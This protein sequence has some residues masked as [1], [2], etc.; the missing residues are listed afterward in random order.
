MTISKNLNGGRASWPLLLFAMFALIGASFLAAAVFPLEQET[1]PA[2][3]AKLE[4]FQDMKFGLLRMLD[5]NL[6]PVVEPGDFR[7]MIGSSSK[8]IRLR[9]MLTVDTR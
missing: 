9:G 1:D 2:V 6:E 5:Q 3:L 8:D 4:W 7:I